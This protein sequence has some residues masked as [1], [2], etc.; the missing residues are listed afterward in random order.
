MMEYKVLWNI[1]SMMI[2]LMIVNEDTQFYAA[3]EADTY[4]DCTR[5]E[6]MLLNDALALEAAQTALI[7]DGK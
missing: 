2:I 7:K 6:D 1:L 4:F 5:F 3:A